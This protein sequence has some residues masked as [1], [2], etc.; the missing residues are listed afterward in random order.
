MNA[1][2]E[3]Q[4]TFFLEA[5]GEN[6][7][8]GQYGNCARKA[9]IPVNARLGANSVH[10]ICSVTGKC[11]LP[12]FAVGDLTPPIEIVYDYGKMFWKNKDGRLEVLSSPPDP[13]EME[14][15]SSVEDKGGSDSDF[16]MP[17]T[18]DASISNAK[19]PTRRSARIAQS[20]KAALFQTPSDK[21]EQDDQDSGIIR[22]PAESPPPDERNVSHDEL[23]MQRLNGT[24]QDM[25]Y[26]VIAGRCVGIFKSATRVYAST[27]SYQGSVVKKCASIRQA[28]LVLH[29]AGIE[30]PRKYWTSQYQ[31]GSLLVSP[32]SV[33]GRRVCFPV[34]HSAEFYR[35]RGSGKVIE[36]LIEHDNRV[37]KIKMPSGFEDVMSEWPLLCG[38]EEQERVFLE[39]S[40]DATVFY[41]IRGT[42]NDGIVTDASSISAR[43]TGDDA[44]VQEFE[45]EQEANEW[46][47]QIIPAPQS[48]SQKFFAIRGGS[49]DGV[50]S[51]CAEI[52]IRMTGEDAEFE[53]FSSFEEA[54]A[55]VQALK[56]FA[57]RLA[58]GLSEVMQL[59]QFMQAVRGKKGIKVEGPKSKAEAVKIVS[60]WKLRAINEQTAAASRTPIPETNAV[61]TKESSQ[62]ARTSTSQAKTCIATMQDGSICGRTSNI[63]ITAL[64]ALCGEH[65]ILCKEVTGSQDGV[66]EDRSSRYGQRKKTDCRRMDN[67]P[68]AG[69][70]ERSSR[71]DSIRSPDDGIRFP[72]KTQAVRRSKKNWV[73]VIAVRTF[74]DEE[75]PDE[76]AGSIWLSMESAEEANKRGGETRLFGKGKSMFENIEA[77]EAWIR[78]Q[79]QKGSDTD[80]EEDDD[81]EFDR[82]MQQARE[83]RQQKSRTSSSASS[84]GRGR[85]RGRGHGKGRGGRGGKGRGA[86]RQSRHAKKS[87][88]DDDENTEE[89]DQ[90]EDESEEEM[91]STSGARGSKFRRRQRKRGGD[92]K[93][94]LRSHV[95]VLLDKEQSRV[96]KQLFH[97]DAEEVR[98][99]E[100]D[101]PVMRKCVKIPLPGKAGALTTSKDAKHVLSFG[102]NM[103]AVLAEKTFKSFKAFSLSDLMEFQQL[104]H[105]VAE[106]QPNERQDLTDSVVEGVNV[107]AANAIQVHASMRDSDSL[108][109]HGENFK[110]YTY[111]QVMYM[112]MFRE[113]FEGSLAEM[114]FWTYAL[115][116][117]VKARGSPGMAPWRGTKSLE[118]NQK[119]SSTE[120]CLFCGKPGHRACSA[121]HQ[122]E[123]AEGSGVYSNDQ[124]K[125]A[126]KNIAGDGKLSADNKKRWSGRVKAFWAKLLAGTEEEQSL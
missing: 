29:D 56:F 84:R 73:T 122:D 82:L 119:V 53:E 100:F 7:W 67:S 97:E 79:V 99:Y 89:S 57:V 85:G 77:A 65:A 35:T 61:R 34:G 33:I 36:T 60:A 30:V 114:F 18:K 6:D 123:Y 42:V 69:I 20:T 121:V 109:P 2:S 95:S 40:N 15:Q 22:S 10:N 9:G 124:M 32:Q 96:E 108:G 116:F 81:A 4:R 1:S 11:W 80:E 59:P 45:S 51:D 55:W 13:R 90:E 70:R 8:E 112:V 28:T 62:V 98:I 103:E 37:W 106:Y 125:K 93:G 86:K 49:R 120:R 118:Q 107:I 68:I 48:Q 111:L 16:V 26:A 117:A 102:N 113:V 23:T 19:K 54:E 50:T 91:H 75:C 43:L 104:V 25:F 3:Y 94:G 44:Q 64:G 101:V 12:I 24:T 74:P 47:R 92:R 78:A 72:D 38:I 17:K 105:Y 66:K 39:T 63:K 115:K 58:S 110:A 71:G 21:R 14:S 126:L 5:R 88:R 52:P 87:N 83:T 46:I 41:A 31:S 76:P 27:S